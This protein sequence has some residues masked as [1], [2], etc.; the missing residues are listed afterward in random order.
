MSKYIICTTEDYA[1]E[2]DYPII[3]IF[4]EKAKNVIIMHNNFLKDDDFSEIYFGTNEYLSF[5]KDSIIDMI[6][7]AKEIESSEIETL[8]KYNCINIGIDIVERALD[9]LYDRAK[10]NGADEL[11]NTLEGLQ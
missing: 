4:S 9:I 10:E 6:K 3:S 1:D 11:A 7:N 5:E 2:F 8:Q